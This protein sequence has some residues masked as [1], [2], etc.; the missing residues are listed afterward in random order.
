MPREA[1]GEEE[2]VP[3]PRRGHRAAE[4]RATERE[5]AGERGGEERWRLEHLAVEGEA[6]ERREADREDVG[7][8]ERREDR[9]SEASEPLRDGV[10]ED[11]LR[12]REDARDDAQRDDVVPAERARDR[13]V[14]IVHQW[15]A[16]AD[17]ALVELLALEQALCE[18]ERVGLVDVGERLV[19]D[20]RSMGAGDR[21]DR[22]AEREARDRE[23]GRGQ[24]RAPVH[25]LSNRD[26]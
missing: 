3:P 26:G 7:G 18:G 24:F 20:E 25:Q 19:A 8:G 5:R 13:F 14:C 15:P 4:R 16:L 12:E 21:G 10:D 17:G 23:L 9:G 22:D 11:E 2:R 1:R 6:I